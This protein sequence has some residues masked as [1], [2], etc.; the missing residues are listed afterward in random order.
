MPKNH[1]LNK[2]ITVLILDN[3]EKVLKMTKNYFLS[4]NITISAAKDIPNAKVQL[5]KNP[6][7]CLVIDTSMENEQGFKFIQRLKNDPKL[8]HVPFIILT[9]RGFVKD[10]LDGYKSGCTA[11]LSKPFNPIELH[12]IVKNLVLKKNLL[13]QKLISNYLL[14]KKLRV[15]VI[16][17]YRNSFKRNL[18]LDLTSKEELILN[19]LLRSKSIKYITEKLKIQTRTI[20]KSVSKI[21]DKTQTK[22]NRNL[23]ILPWNVL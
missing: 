6:I 12:Y 2:L 19:Y 1:F 15:N 16:K 18:D 8:Q 13:S 21:L 23:K 9:S 17:K 22:S 4:N 11:Y 3:E 10:R 7:D 14:L 5:K 20:E